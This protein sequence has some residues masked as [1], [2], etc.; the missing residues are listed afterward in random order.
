[1]TWPTSYHPRRAARVASAATWMLVFSLWSSSQA[2]G[3][4]L[5]AGDIIVNEST[6]VGE[7]L[8][9]DPFTGELTHISSGGELAYSQGRM[10]LD[11]DG[12]IIVV[13]GDGVLRVDPSTGTQTV[14]SSGGSFIRLSA[15]A[16]E[17]SGNLIVTD[18]GVFGEAGAIIRVDPI[19]GAQTIVSSGE[20]LIT[21]GGVAIDPNGEILVA[22]ADTWDRSGRVIRIDPTTGVQTVVSSGGS[23]LDPYDI[24]ID[25]NG[26]LLIADLSSFEGP[27]YL[28]GCGGIIQ[29]DPVTGTQTSVSEG[30]IFTNPLSIAIEANGDL[31]VTDYHAFSGLPP[32]LIRVDPATG[33]Q[34]VVSSTFGSITDVLVVPGTPA[35]PD[36]F[37]GDHQVNQPEEQCDRTDSGSCP[38]PC[39]PDC[40]CFTGL[41]PG[42]I[43]LTDP[44]LSAVVHVDAAT[45]DRTVLSSAGVGTGPALAF[46]TGIAIRSDGDLFVF[47]KNPPALFRIDPKTGDRTIVSSASVGVGPDFGIVNAI[48]L[49]DDGSIVVGSGNP[50]AL[51]RVDPATGNRTILASDSVGSGDSVG[52]PE[53]LAVEA[54]GSILFVNGFPGRVYRVDPAT[55]DRT[56][57]S[58]TFAVHIGTGPDFEA[59]QGVTVEESGD[60]LVADAGSLGFWTR[61]YR[62]DPSSG[63][64]VIISGCTGSTGTPCPLLGSGTPFL[65]PQD[66]EAEQGGTILVTDTYRDTLF[67]V[68]PM[69]G[70]RTSFSSPGTAAGPELLGPWSL[71]IVPM[72][73]DSDGD[74]VPDLRDLC[75]ESPSDN[76]VNGD[77]CSIRQLVPCEGS[78]S[79]RMWKNHG[80]YLLSVAMTTRKFLREG[81]I[82]KKQAI[83]I[84]RGAARDTCGRRL[85]K[86]TPPPP[87]KIHAARNH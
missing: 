49:A 75:R 77:G 1:M 29:V 52:W 10:A 50:S 83:T 54:D 48:A 19:T 55:G 24:T 43:V 62:V 57:V 51:F 16:I 32:R 27:C 40:T 60:I 63:D 20:G 67:R 79:G 76:V 18:T 46:P 14:I 64:R 47:D 37:C 41:E 53:G 15:V 33:D 71:E 86:R 81:L 70:D 5:R 4:E 87:R 65:F 80:H 9:L 7:I 11:A 78:T 45:G 74:G 84:L 12:D 73:L 36:P 31:L 25:P 13:S 44:V 6:I 26:N 38:G 42:D 8:R 58:S 35:R 66:L 39:K 59:P 30:G 22:D 21:P 2:I 82:S 28:M 23:F 69:T 85:K 34:T 3:V 61:L 72:D 68:D 56:I 17:E